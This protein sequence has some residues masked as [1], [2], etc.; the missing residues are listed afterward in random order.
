MGNMAKIHSW[1]CRLWNGDSKGSSC[2]IEMCLSHL[3]VVDKL[4]NL[5][6]SVTSYGWQLGWGVYYLPHGFFLRMEYVSICGIFST[7]PGIYINGIY[8][9]C[10]YIVCYFSPSYSYVAFIDSSRTRGL[11]SCSGTRLWVWILAL[12]CLHLKAVKPWAQY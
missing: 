12:P 6:A 2:G 9:S 10:S 3:P 11:K 7:V 4:L 5:G 1:K 8:V